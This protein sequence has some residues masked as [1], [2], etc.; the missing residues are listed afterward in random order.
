[1]RAEIRQGFLI[2]PFEI[3][4]DDCRHGITEYGLHP[5]LGQA[6]AFGPANY[7]W[8][9][10]GLATEGGVASVLRGLGGWMGRMFAGESRDFGTKG[11]VWLTR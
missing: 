11:R 7:N 8:V 10:G 1:M 4:F 9:A 5:I 3:T 2:V 6:A